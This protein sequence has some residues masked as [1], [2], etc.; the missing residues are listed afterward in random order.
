MLMP[1]CMFMAEYV[2]TLEV[3]EDE[4]RRLDDGNARGDSF[5]LVVD[6]VGADRSSSE[7]RLPNEWMLILD[8]VD[9]FLFVIRRIRRG[10]RGPRIWAML[11]PVPGPGPDPAVPGLRFEEWEEGVGDSVKRDMVQ[12]SV[13]LTYPARDSSLKRDE[14]D[15]GTLLLLVLRS[16]G[17]RWS[18]S[19]GR[20][21]RAANGACCGFSEPEVRGRMR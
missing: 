6:V 20:R 14:Y 10:E 11:C 12:L 5:V 4:E 9:K 2:A 17:G 18:I 13:S 15:D 8:D 19:V 16:E 1:M 3:D 21:D 7:R